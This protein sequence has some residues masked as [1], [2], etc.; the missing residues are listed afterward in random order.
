M[1]ETSIP[2]TLAFT[3]TTVA[4][5]EMVLLVDKIKK[6]DMAKLIEYLQGQD[7][8][9]DDDNLKIFHK[10]KIAGRAFLKMD[11]QDFRDSGFEIGIAIVLAD[12]VKE[13][14]IKN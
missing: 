11:K 3:S 10:R 12:F 13:S 8:G 4:E 2:Y 5:N 14:R 1:S 7:L 9:L 6:Y